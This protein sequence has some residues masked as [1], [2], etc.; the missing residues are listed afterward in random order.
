[1]ALM[2]ARKA[3]QGQALDVLPV[4][5]TME[6]GP[7]HGYFG[8]ETSW[9]LDTNIVMKNLIVSLGAVVDKEYALFEKRLA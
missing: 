6:R 2:G 7:E 4:L 3:Y 1:M 5:A 9:V 8:C